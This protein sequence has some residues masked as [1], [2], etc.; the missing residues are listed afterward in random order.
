MDVHAVP[1]GADVGE[2]VG[3]DLVFRRLCVVQESDAAA[4]RAHLQRAQHRHRGRDA[5]PTGD[6]HD[7]VRHVVGEHELALR[8]GEVDHR[9]DLR[10]LD[11]V[12]RDHAVGVGAHR[13]GEPVPRLRVGAGD[14]EDAG[15]T[16]GAVDLDAQL[17]VLPGAVA[18]PGRG[19][20]QG[21][22]G[23]RR[24]AGDVDLAVDVD[25]PGAHLAG[26]PHR[27]DLLEVAVDAVRR[28][29]RREGPRLEHGLGETHG[30]LLRTIE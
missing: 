4:M 21:D 16:T 11:E 5:G 29:E 30:C 15:R 8:L 28:G 6:E 22:R 3:E 14:G 9:A 1:G 20:L 12:A 13:D 2:L 18:A 10:P 7:V 26:R 25:D 19:R 17:D 24:V 23:D 27:V